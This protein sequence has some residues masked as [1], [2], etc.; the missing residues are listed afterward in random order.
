LRKIL[1][2]AGV[3]ALALGVAGPA[4]AKPKPI[5]QA[6]TLACQV[7]DPQ[8]TEPVVAQAA[9]PTQDFTPTADFAMTYAGPLTG[10]GLAGGPVFIGTNNNRQDGSQDW[11]FAIVGFVPFPGTDPPFPFGLNA[12]DLQLYAGRPIA[13]IEY[14][15][16]GQFSGLCAR[17]PKYGGLVLAGCNNGP[18]EAWIITQHPPFVNPSPSPYTYA[19]LASHAATA[20]RHFCLTAP[21]AP[22]DLSGQLTDLACQHASLG[23]ATD[24]MW[25]AIP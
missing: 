5:I 24:Q 8:C 25:S 6:P 12:T 17:Q 15:P 11:D 23:T 3:L 10:I 22:F 14:T 1:F 4:M 20:Q 18:R 13:Q 2:V 19:L 16:F 21:S 7:T 9:N